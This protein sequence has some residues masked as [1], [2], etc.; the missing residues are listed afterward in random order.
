MKTA[1]MTVVA[2]GLACAVGFA[3][4]AVAAQGSR[5]SQERPV[6]PRVMMLDGRGAQIGV[7]VNDVTEGVRIEEVDQDG[8]ASKAGL[9]AGDIVVEFDG[10]RVRSARQFSRLI[11][12][13]A[14]GRSVALGIMRDGKRQVLNVTPESRAFGFDF[15]SDLLQREIARGMRDVEPR[16]RELE[17]RLREFG[18]NAPFHFDFDALPRITSPRARLGV[19][20]NELTPQLGEYFGAK[21]GGVLVTSVTPDSP[22]AKAGLKAGDVITSIDGGRVRRREDLIDQLRDK[23]GDVTVGILR[24][25][26]ESSVKAT[27]EATSPR[28]GFR[29]PA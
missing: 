28:A 20:L 29:R 26:Q 18:F 12:E 19:L 10:E 7:H 8:P 23:D 14:E 5:D 11:Q 27:L 15:D 21:D 4:S 17:P 24:D 25:K 16:L 9:Q 22:A 1:K 3:V 2:L 6:R 13:T